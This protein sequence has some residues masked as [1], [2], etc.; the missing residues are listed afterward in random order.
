MISYRSAEII[1]GYSDGQPA[2]VFTRHLEAYTSTLD[3]FRRQE[4]RLLMT[5]TR[6]FVRYRSRPV[7]TVVRMLC[8]SFLEHIY[9]HRFEVEYRELSF[10][11]RLVWHY[12]TVESEQEMAKF[13]RDAAFYRQFGHLL[14]EKGVISGYQGSLF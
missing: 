10:L 8:S 1:F 11:L 7:E 2:P 6:V 3:P 14:L 5:T 4:L 12:R 13:G 9:R